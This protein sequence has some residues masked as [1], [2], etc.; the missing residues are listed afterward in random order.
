[1]K[2]FKIGDFVYGNYG[3]E[4]Y[5]SGE[6]KKIEGNEISIQCNRS[7]VTLYEPDVFYDIPEGKKSF[8]IS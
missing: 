3:I 4:S 6:I 1:M 8:F 5:I 2:D 7:L